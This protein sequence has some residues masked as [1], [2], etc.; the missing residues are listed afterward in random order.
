MTLGIEREYGDLIEV[1][2]SEDFA[3]GYTL[4]NQDAFLSRELAD[5][6]DERYEDFI[7]GSAD[8]IK[9]YMLGYQN[10]LWNRVSELT[11]KV[12]ELEKK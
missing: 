8:Y 7:N 6:R 5:K 2:C 1:E 3:K 4:G 11:A 10:A 12:E 9:G